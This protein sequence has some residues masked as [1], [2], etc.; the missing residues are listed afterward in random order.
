MHNL[1]AFMYCFNEDCGI[2]P[3]VIYATGTAS[4]SLSTVTRL[5]LTLHT[6]LSLS[7][8]PPQRS[9]SLSPHPPQP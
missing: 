5:S 9:A 8:H 6:R 4:A 1:L 3:Q 2:L 7:L